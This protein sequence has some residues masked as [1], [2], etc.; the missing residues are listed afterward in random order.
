MV[1]IVCVSF[2]K[3]LLNLEVRTVLRFSPKIF[4][5]TLKSSLYLEL[6]FLYESGIQFVSSL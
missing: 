4:V 1:S 5:L 3:M 2:I 6:I